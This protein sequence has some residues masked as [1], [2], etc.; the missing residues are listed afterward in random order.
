MPLIGFAGAP[1]TLASYLI[2]GG[3]SANFAKTKKLMFGAPDAWHALMEK[4]AEVVRRY[5]LAQIAAGADAVQLFDSWVGR[6]RAGGLRRVRAAARRG[7][8][9]PTSRRPGVPVIHF[10]TGTATLLEPMRDAGRDGHR[11]RLVHAARRRRGRASAT[12]ARCRGTWTRARSSRRARSRWRTRSASSTRGRPPRAHL[13]PRPRHLAGDAGR[14][15]AGGHRLRA[16]GPPRDDVRGARCS[17]SS[18]GTVDDRST[19]SRRFVTNVRRGHPPS[20]RARRRASTAVRRRSAGVAAQ[21][22]QRRGRGA[23]SNGAS[24]SAWRG[25]IACGTRRRGACSRSSRAEGVDASALV[26]LAQHSAHVYAD[27]A[28]EPAA[29]CGIA[30]ASAPNWG[31][32]PEAVRRGGVADRADAQRVAGLGAGG[33]G[34]DGAQPAPGGRRRGGSVRARSPRRGARH[35]ARSSR[36]RGRGAG[37]A[38]RR[39]VSEPGTSAGPGGRPMPW[40]GPDLKTTLDEAAARGRK[41]RRVRAHRLSRRPRRDPLRP[42]HRGARPGRRSG[43]R[44]HACAV[45]Q[46]RRRLHRRPRR[47]GAAALARARAR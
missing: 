37:A 15:R 45:A 21:R 27:D 13:Q 20:P 47:R 36:G 19:T 12:T 2:E 25:R 24:A 33:A 44:G 31:S 18:H 35:R 38:R 1:F 46:R 3:K 14:Q 32:Q 29:A 40:L 16:R 11:R 6:P 34:D 39:R 9:S 5:L 10:G 30:L 22:D 42:R 17:S 26:P 43:P 8:S 23:S 28:R 41:A 4:L 7:T